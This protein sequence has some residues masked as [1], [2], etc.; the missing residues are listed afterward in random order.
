MTRR[1]QRGIGLLDAL[2]A[3]A[4][5]AFGLLALTRFQGRMTSQSTDAQARQTANR[6]ADELVSM[7]LVDPGNI[8]CYTLPAAGAC[9]NAA[10]RT[11]T[12]GW[13]TRVTSSLPGSATA[14][15]T[16]APPPD[17]AEGGTRLTIQISWTSKDES[18]DARQLVTITN[19]Q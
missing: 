17:P 3:L 18:A 9:G 7:A 2:I 1:A 8:G 10:V 12:N 13:L 11:N 5:L 15:V 14:T 19:V 6:L 16:A 4:I